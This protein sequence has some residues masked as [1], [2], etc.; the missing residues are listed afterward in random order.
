[1]KQQM[2]TMAANTPPSH[3]LRS[4]AA[5]IRS[6]DRQSAADEMAVGRLLIMAKGLLPHG[7]FIPWLESQGDISPRA[8]QRCMSAAKRIKLPEQFLRKCLPSTVRVLAARKVAKSTR[9]TNRAADTAPRNGRVGYRD[10][11]SELSCEDPSA[12]HP[13]H[14]AEEGPVEAIGRRLQSVAA[15]HAIDSIFITFDRDAD[16]LPQV[17][18]TIMGEHPRTIARTTIAELLAALAGE[19][20]MIR[21]ARCERD[22]PPSLFSLSSHNCKT[23]ERA[24]VGEYTKKKRAENRETKRRIDEMN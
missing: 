10:M 4:I 16:E 17:A 9:L 8:A 3:Q 6:I 19:E 20:K 13:L 21:C 1:M 15:N 23:C 12:V 14:H 18:A 24:R 11:L 7:Q 5:E 2:R 22:L